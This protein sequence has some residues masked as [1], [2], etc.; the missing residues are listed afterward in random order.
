MGVAVG[1]IISDVLNVIGVKQQKIYLLMPFFATAVFRVGLC[2]YIVNCAWIIST[3]KPWS[4][5]SNLKTDDNSLFH[6]NLLRIGA[7]GLLTVSVIILNVVLVVQFW[8]NERSF[9]QI[10]HNYDI[11]NATNE[12]VNVD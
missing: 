6:S 5:E 9:T 4:H 8:R 11:I 12:I 7:Y 10:M 3:V 2:I 1:I